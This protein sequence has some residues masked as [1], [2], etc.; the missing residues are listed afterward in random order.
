MELISELLK[1]NKVLTHITLRLH[2][3]LWDEVLSIKENG[4]YLPPVK[5]NQTW[6]KLCELLLLNNN[7]KE[8]R[9]EIYLDPMTPQRKARLAA[10]TG[11]FIKTTQI[12]SA[13]WKKVISLVDPTTKIFSAQSEQ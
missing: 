8:N 3:N 2:Y 10:A 4:K 7:L 6:E 9:I 1:E 11:K 13:N 12:L 5:L